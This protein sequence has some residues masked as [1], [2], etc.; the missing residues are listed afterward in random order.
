MSSSQSSVHWISGRN[1][2]LIHWLEARKSRVDSIKYN[3]KHYETKKPRKATSLTTLQMLDMCS[4]DGPLSRRTRY[5]AWSSHFLL[6]LF[7]S[8]I[9]YILTSLASHQMTLPL[10]EFSA[11]SYKKSWDNEHYLWYCCCFSSNKTTMVT[12]I[13]HRSTLDFHHST[14]SESRSCL[15]IHLN[16]DSGTMEVES[17]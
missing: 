5:C 3:T 6:Y 10:V 4:S 7:R 17:E 15:L 9:S 14:I 2:A 11:A 16:W 12:L 1:C 8:S 13:C